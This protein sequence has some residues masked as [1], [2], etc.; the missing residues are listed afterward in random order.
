MSVAGGP[1]RVIGSLPP[2]DLPA[3]ATNPGLRLSLTPDG[4]SFAY[5][6]VRNSSSL[7]LMDG[8]KS[9]TAR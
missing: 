7:W 2:D 9:M 5:S 3:S 4:K 1:E 6:T 8:L